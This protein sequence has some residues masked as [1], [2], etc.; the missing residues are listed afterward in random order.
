[1]NENT[2]SCAGDKDTNRDHDDDGYDHDCHYE[3]LGRWHRIR[4]NYKGISLVAND[5][6]PPSSPLISSYNLCCIFLLQWRGRKL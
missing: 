4:Q 1:M 2:I 3:R 6:P 5:S